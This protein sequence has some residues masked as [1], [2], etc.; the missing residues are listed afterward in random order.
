MTT[1]TTLASVASTIWKMAKRSPFAVG[2]KMPMTSVR[3]IAVLRNPRRVA[4]VASGMIAHSRYQGCATGK[5][6]HRR[7]EC[8][9]EPADR[10]ESPAEHREQEQRDENRK[11]DHPDHAGDAEDGRGVVAESEEDAD[12]TGAKGNQRR[13]RHPRSDDVRG[14]EGEEPSEAKAADPADQRDD[15]DRYGRQRAAGQHECLERSA[16]P[17]GECHRHEPHRQQRRQLHLRRHGDQHRSDD[18]HGHRFPA[19]PVVAACGPVQWSGDQ[20]A[21]GVDPA[22]R[23]LRA[24]QHQAEHQRLVVDA[25]EEVHEERAGCTVPATAR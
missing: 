6:Q 13:R 14:A 25:P 21:G 11:D 9:A 8:G 5:Q 7:A 16:H 2:P 24:H 17:V 20:R 1:I 23:E 19:D 12:L 15:R 18:Q 22:Q 4:H 10:M 3:V